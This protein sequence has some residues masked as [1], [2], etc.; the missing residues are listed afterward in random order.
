MYDL[1]TFCIQNSPTVPDYDSKKSRIVE[2]GRELY[3]D[4]GADAMVNMY[5]AVQN[6][7]KEEIQKDANPYRTLWNGITEEWKY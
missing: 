2:I 5:F 7:I 3:S 1:V 6:R 4:G